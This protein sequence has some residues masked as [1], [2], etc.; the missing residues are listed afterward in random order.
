[1]FNIPYDH[2]DFNS[3]L[4]M[5]MPT[6]CL[7]GGYKLAAHHVEDE[8]PAKAWTFMASNTRIDDDCMLVFRKEEKENSYTGRCMTAS[9]RE[10]I[11]GYPRYESS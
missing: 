9:E 8:M 1:V 2:F 5:V 6:K 11:M 10:V 7:E 4:S 3:P